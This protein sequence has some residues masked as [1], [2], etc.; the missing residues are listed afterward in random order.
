MPDKMMKN[1][2]PIPPSKSV[3]WSKRSIEPTAINGRKVA[4]KSKAKA[5]YPQT[6]NSYEAI[7][8][9]VTIGSSPAEV[10]AMGADSKQV[11]IKV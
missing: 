7:K 8:S 4:T 5:T 9:L 10:P 11:H 2:A 1:N 6:L 3:Q